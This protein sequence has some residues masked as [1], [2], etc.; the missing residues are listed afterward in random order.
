MNPVKKEKKKTIPQRRISAKQK[1]IA[2]NKIR[3]KDRRK[4]Q[5]LEKRKALMKN[6][7]V[8]RTN[9]EIKQKPV[10]QAVT[11]MDVW[12][13]MMSSP[14]TMSYNL[15]MEEVA[16]RNAKVVKKEMKVYVPSAKAISHHKY[17]LQSK[18]ENEEK[19]AVYLEQQQKKKQLRKQ[20][21]QLSQNR[22]VCIQKNTKLM[23][24][25]LIDAKKLVENDKWEFVSKSVWK[26]ARANGEG[27]YELYWEVGKAN[28]GKIFT[29]PNEY[30]RYAKTT[31]K[32]W[33]FR[34]SKER[35]LTTATIK[36]RKR[37]HIRVKKQT[38]ISKFYQTYLVNPIKVI[39]LANYT[40]CL[41]NEETN[42]YY[43]FNPKKFEELKK[44]FG[45]PT[46]IYEAI[47]AKNKAVAGTYNYG[48]T[49]DSAFLNQLI[50]SGYSKE[51]H[52]EGI[53]IRDYNK[54]TYL[55]DGNTNQ[56]HI[57][58]KKFFSE[59]LKKYKI[60]ANIVKELIDGNTDLTVKVRSLSMSSDD[61][62]KY[63]W[64]NLK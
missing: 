35:T 50:G 7:A 44:K 12:K 25:R 16:R 62:K 13:E 9:K 3:L 24:I 22:L 55:L 63:H 39:K 42:T 60:P 15:L 52:V 20:K 21:N 2:R 6:R 14:W 26:E 37:K 40:T 38:T 32:E 57:F 5:K 33:K 59:C 27:S 28:L 54:N 53:V 36:R 56:C 58:T 43:E 41:V 4:L 10:K 1:A 17:V 51:L 48:S 49:N 30:K 11:L 23:R 19:K 46:R 47:E 45:T 29:K 18:K 64:P 8:K 31:R 61:F 34:D